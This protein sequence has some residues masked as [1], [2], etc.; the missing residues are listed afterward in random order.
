[1]QPIQQPKAYQIF[2]FKKQIN[3]RQ[4]GAQVIVKA[5][6][7]FAPVL[8]RIPPREPPSQKKRIGGYC[9]RAKCQYLNLTSLEPVGE[10]TGYDDDMIISN[11][12]EEMCDRTAKQNGTKCTPVTITFLHNMNGL[13][14]EGI[15]INME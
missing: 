7:Q 10:I 2:Q 8:Q 5:Q 12:V 11:L 15:F 13:P 9:I 14:C 3:H 4:R 1:M 6:S